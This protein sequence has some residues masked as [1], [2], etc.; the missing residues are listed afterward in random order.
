MIEILAN[1]FRSVIVLSSHDLL[2]SV[3]L[4]LNQ[5]APAHEGVELEVGETNFMK[6]IAQTT[7]RSMDK[8]KADV[9]NTGDLGI[10]AEKSRSSQR[11]FTPAPHTVEGMFTKVK[12]ITKMS[13]ATAMLKKVDTIKGIFVACQHSEARFF[14]RS[15]AGKLS[16]SRLQ[17]DHPSHHQG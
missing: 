9:Q 8:I 7:G 16:V 2:P 17:S 3:Y 10:I 12:N 1:Y 14:I 4:C 5:L 6:A 15:L 11:M 13:G